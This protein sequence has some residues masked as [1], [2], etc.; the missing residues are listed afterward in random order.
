MAALQALRL[1]V[2]R[3]R[4]GLRRYSST[5]EV[6]P[7]AVHSSVLMFFPQLVGFIGLGNMGGPMANNLIK[8]GHQLVVFDLMKPAVESAVAAGAIKADSPSQVSVALR[9]TAFDS[10]AD[11]G[12]APDVRQWAMM[13]M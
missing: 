6:L 10:T 12:H 2:W 3:G 8:K 5:K 1:G 13:S 9:I 11:M 7:V 4:G